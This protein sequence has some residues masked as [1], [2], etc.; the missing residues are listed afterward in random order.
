MRLWVFGSMWALAACGGTAAECGPAECAEVCAKQAPAPSAEAPAEEA[1]KGMDADL[2]EWEQSILATSVEAVKKGVHLFDEEG[3]GV[4]KG[5]GRDCE[6]FLGTDAGELPPGDY[7][8]Q[9]RLAVPQVGD[10]ETWKVHFATK[11]ETIRVAA[12]GKEV[13]SEREH[14]KEYTVRFAG[15]DKPYRLAPLRRITSPAK[16]GRMEC[17]YTLTMV[18]PDREEVLTGSYKVPQEAS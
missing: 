3:F 6:G 14:D 7:M 12:D 2:S 15:P 18:R 9:A 10:A 4:C 17:S 11:C 13:R 16:G 1:P 8:I 5:T